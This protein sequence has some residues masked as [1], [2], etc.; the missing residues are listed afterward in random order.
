MYMSV[1]CVCDV[2]KYVCISVYFS[3]RL[4]QLTIYIPL[5]NLSFRLLYIVTILLLYTD[6][7]INVY[8]CPYLFA[9]MYTYIPTYTYHYTLYSA[10]LPYY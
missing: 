2:Y 3:S 5:F 8:L 4:Q 9:F 7:F 6:I 10:H 1:Y